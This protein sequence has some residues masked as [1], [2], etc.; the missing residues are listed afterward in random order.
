ME[1]VCAWMDTG[2]RALRS[3]S[4]SPPG[5]PWLRTSASPAWPISGFAFRWELQ[6][7]AGDLQRRDALSSQPP[8]LSI[9]LTSRVSLVGE[10]HWRVVPRDL[11]T[12][13]QRAPLLQDL[14]YGLLKTTVSHLSKP[15]KTGR[16]QRTSFTPRHGGYAK[17]IFPRHKQP[18][19][20]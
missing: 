14:S 15:R 17:T 2:S 5:A 6:F 1:R 3:G 20:C 19:K 18:E 10:Q 8:A 12:Q 4:R 7:F 9:V 13:P 11:P 16:H